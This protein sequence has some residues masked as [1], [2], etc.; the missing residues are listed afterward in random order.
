MDHIGVVGVSCVL[1]NWH[2]GWQLDAAG[3]L[4]QGVLLNQAGCKKHWSRQRV[5]T[6][7]DLDELQRIVGKRAVGDVA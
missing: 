4:A 3:V 2:A 7:V 6:D 1:T 5:A